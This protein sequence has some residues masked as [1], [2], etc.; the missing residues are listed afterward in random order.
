MVFFKDKVY[1]EISIARPFI[2]AF[3]DEYEDVG[4]YKITII[5]TPLQK[6]KLREKWNKL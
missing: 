3:D 1:D 6:R 4:Y 2:L 5:C